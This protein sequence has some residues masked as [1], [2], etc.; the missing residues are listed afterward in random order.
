MVCM[1]TEGPPDFGKYLRGRRAAMTPPD[2]DWNGRSSKRRVPGLRRQELSEVAGISV[3]YYIRLE[4]GRAPRPSREVLTALAGALVLSGAE[5]DHLFRLAGEIPPEPD[6]PEADVRPGLLRMLRGLGDAV[7]V[8]VHDGRLVLLA[9]NAAAADLFGPMS[10]HGPFRSN[11]VHQS[12]TSVALRDAL[13]PDGAADLARAATAELRAAL[14]RYPN[15][16]YLASLLAELAATS[17]VF[18]E[19]WER[20]EVGSERSRIK[21]LRHPTEGWLEFDTEMLHD[22]DRDH[23]VSIYTRRAPACAAV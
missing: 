14:G 18:L 17:A 1:H 11:V 22:P 20:G 8:T 21:R 9:R 6:A 12:L 5:Q 2:Q 7:P 23:W 4:Q 3:D 19:H 15:D 13:G 10:S 16:S